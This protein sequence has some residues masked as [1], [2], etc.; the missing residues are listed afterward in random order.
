MIVEGHHAGDLFLHYLRLQLQYRQLI[1]EDSRAFRLRVDF[2]IVNWGTLLK[3]TLK[4]EFACFSVH[5]SADQSCP[6]GNK[7]QDWPVYKLPQ[8]FWALDGLRKASYLSDSPEAFAMALGAI[9]DGTPFNPVADFVFDN[10]D[11]CLELFTTAPKFSELTPFEGDNAGAFLD[12]GG[13]ISVDNVRPW[14]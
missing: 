4:A 13:K 2:R 11:E 9:Q 5:P 7:F 3:P 1:P 14:A 8:K 10:S 12:A 6:P